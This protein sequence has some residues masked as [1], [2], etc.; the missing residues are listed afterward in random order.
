MTQFFLPILTAT[1]PAAAAAGEGVEMSAGT[2]IMAT[3]VQVLPLLLV[4]VLFYFL[5]IRPQKK[6]EKEVNN[7]RREIQIGD[8]VATVGGIIGIVIRKNEDNLVIET[9][10]DRSKIRVKLWAIQENMTI[11]DTP[12]S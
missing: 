3:L 2:T 6:K 5:F 8:E 10:G 7:M 4:F 11:H 1:A 9:G 12:E